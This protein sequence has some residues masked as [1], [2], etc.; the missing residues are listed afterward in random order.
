MEDAAELGALAFVL[1]G[2]SAWNQVWL[3]WPGIAWILPPSAGIHQL[4]MT[5]GDDDL[6]I[7]DGAGRDVE[8]ADR[9]RAWF[10]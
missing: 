4:W 9:P 3:I 8:R 6:E 2:F 10:G 1:P 5:S 7:D